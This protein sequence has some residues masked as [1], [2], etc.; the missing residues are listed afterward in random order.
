MMR[1]RDVA[2]DK[3]RKRK[4]NDLS[5]CHVRFYESIVC[6]MRKDD[7]D[8]SIKRQAEYDIGAESM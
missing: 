3:K 8:Q 1:L 4:I 2:I 6:D 7:Y 5:P